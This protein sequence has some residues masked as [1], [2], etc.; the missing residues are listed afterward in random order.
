MFK[1]KGASHA[2]NTDGFE[3]TFRGRDDLLYIEHFEGDQRR[4][5]TAPAEM[6]LGRVNRAI[7]TGRFF[8]KHWD[9]P[10][11]AESIADEER[12]QIVKRITAS[13]DFL[14]ITYELEQ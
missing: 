1:R 9:P 7:S 2:V 12:E 5:L 6:L 14:H 3:V 11:E 10:H 13:L 4:Q 8:P